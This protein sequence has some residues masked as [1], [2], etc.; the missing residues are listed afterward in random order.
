MQACPARR[1]Q[2]AGQARRVQLRRLAHDPWGHSTSR[3][4]SAT[5]RR[6]PTGVPQISPGRQAR[7]ADPCAMVVFGASGDLTRRLV[8]PALY[9]LART[10]ILPEKFALI[11][12]DLAPGTTASWRHHLR[13]TLEGFVANAGSEFNIDQIDDTVW[14]R[15]AEKMLYI[16]GD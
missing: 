4:H 15:I 7:P 5:M 12:V 3:P 10:K 14:N 16:P 6:S 13:D 1:I 2:S 9:N 11:G 8:I